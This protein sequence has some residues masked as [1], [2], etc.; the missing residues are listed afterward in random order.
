MHNTYLQTINHTLV[1][2]FPRLNYL[3]IPSTILYYI[4]PLLLRE[5]LVSLSHSYTHHISTAYSLLQHL[6]RVLFTYRHYYSLRMLDQ[7]TNHLAIRCY[8][9]DHIVHSYSPTS[10]IQYSCFILLDQEVST[11]QL[12]AADRINAILWIS[13]VSLIVTKDLIR[14][15]VFLAY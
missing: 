11:I 4:Q 15:W 1:L 13:S 14:C 12:I 10:Y 2:E 7:D 8:Q 5:P 3:E 9:L 6:T